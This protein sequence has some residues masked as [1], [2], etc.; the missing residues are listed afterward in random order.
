MVQ[1][2]IRVIDAQGQRV[3]EWKSGPV[4]T[5][6]QLEQHIGHRIGIGVHPVARVLE[7]LRGRSLSYETYDLASMLLESIDRAGPGGTLEVL[8]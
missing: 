6:E 3:S 2:T 5:W 4:Q 1:Y 8:P 7:A